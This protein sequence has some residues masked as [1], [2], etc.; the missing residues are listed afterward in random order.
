MLHQILQVQVLVVETVI[1]L[2][3]DLPLL[4]L[5]AVVVVEAE[6][7]PLQILLLLVKQVGQVVA[8]QASGDQEQ[9]A[10][11]IYIQVPSN[12]VFQAD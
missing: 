3:Q 11:D 4:L 7:A 10:T 8:E 5:W 9:R 1:S 6:Q 2:A 12:K